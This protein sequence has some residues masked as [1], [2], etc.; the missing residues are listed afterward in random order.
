MLTK[1]RNYITC[2]NDK[3]DYVAG[4]FSICQCSKI[5]AKVRQNFEIK[6]WCSSLDLESFVIV[7]AWGGG[8]FVW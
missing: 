8:Q 5:G 4:V 3:N 6:V 7:R 1:I 2:K